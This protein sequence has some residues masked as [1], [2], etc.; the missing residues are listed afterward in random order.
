[1]CGA[2]K[3]QKRDCVLCALFNLGVQ[4]FDSIGGLTIVLTFEKSDAL[5]R[6]GF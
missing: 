3:F 4:M 2:C 5:P 6:G 1:M